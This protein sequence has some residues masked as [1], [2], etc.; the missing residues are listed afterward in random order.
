MIRLKKTLVNIFFILL[1]FCFISCSNDEA[2]TQNVSDNAELEYA[3]ENSQLKKEI[4][5]L[6]EKSDSY[7]NENIKLKKDL[8]E[9]VENLKVAENIIIE[10][11]I[12]NLEN[13]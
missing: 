6:K 8:K 1:S 7:S 12:N 10:L 2:I 4:N 5:N 9:A 11:S 13:I 3:K